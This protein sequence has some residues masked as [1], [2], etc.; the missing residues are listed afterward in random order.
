MSKSSSL[1]EYLSQIL[2]KGDFS[3]LDP[4]KDPKIWKTMESSDRL[5]LAKLFTEHAAE[6]LEKNQK[7]KEAVAILK[8][9]TKAA[10]KDVGL[11]LKQ[12]EILYEQTTTKSSLKLASK[13]LD[14]VVKIDKNCFEAWDLLASI[15]YEQLQYDDDISAL[16]D[17][18]DKFEKAQ[19]LWSEEVDPQG[20][21]FEQWAFRWSVIG[22]I[23]GEAVDLHRSTALY[24]QAINMGEDKSSE[25]YNAYGNTLVSLGM[26]IVSPENLEDAI[27]LYEEAVSEDPEFFDA[28]MNLACTSGYLLEIWKQVDF[29]DIAQKALMKASEICETEPALWFKWG[30]LQAFMGALSSDTQLVKESLENFKKANDLAPSHFQIQYEWARAL[31]YVGVHDENLEQIHLALE[32]AKECVEIECEEPR[33]WLIN[34]MVLLELG[35]YFEDAEHVRE[36]IEKFQ[37]GLKLDSAQS[38]LWFHL[39]L[40]YLHIGE[41][42]G[43]ISKFEEAVNY[44]ARAEEFGAGHDPQFWFEWGNLYMRLGQLTQRKGYTRKALEAYEKMFPEEED[45]ESD[46]IPSTH[47]MIGYALA[48]EELGLEENSTEFTEKAIEIFLKILMI[49]PDAYIVRFHLGMA[50]SHLA[51]MRS[52]LAQYYRATDS[53][54]IYSE[55]ENEDETLW[56]EWGRVLLHM[57][58]MAHDPAH[59][60]LHL[61]FL[62]DAEKKL[63]T[64]AGLGAIHAYNLL[65]CLYI[66]KKDYSAAIQYLE[67]A[68]DA[69]LPLDEDFLANEGSLQELRETPGFQALL[70]RLK[71]QEN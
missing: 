29:Y 52:D 22:E 18:A 4:Y 49:D 31:L 5:T 27:S 7:E 2:S 46:G 33:A 56:I 28:W 16:D 40:A 21:F 30:S 67:K 43:E 48:W 57:A 71:N 20:L 17:V 41:F 55:Y 38:S 25:F 37:S 26:L 24:Q 6:L 36:A 19:N 15:C 9:A 62:E 64:A 61:S 13:L 39:A 68:L 69:G 58:H 60:N 10:P 12:A 65:A 35:V 59:P 51:S 8:L 3:K 44:F 70:D 34:G 1:S 63:L 45:E 50:Y 66:L 32:R 11:L 14:K 42:T 23:S 53:F 47:H 54:Q